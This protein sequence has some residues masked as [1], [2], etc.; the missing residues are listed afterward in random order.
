MNGQFNPEDHFPF[1]EKH[2]NKIAWALLVTVLV[3][4]ICVALI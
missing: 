1:G 3:F 4:N 2:G